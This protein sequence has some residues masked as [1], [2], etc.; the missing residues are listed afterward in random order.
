MSHVTSTT[1]F[2]NV[3]VKKK[4]TAGNTLLVIIF[5]SLYAYSL[6]IYLCSDFLFTKGFL[7][8]VYSQCFGYETQVVVRSCHLTWTCCK[9]FKLSFSAFCPNRLFFN[10]ISNCFALSLEIS[11]A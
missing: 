4:K 3:L 6:F 10:R 8:H 7:H 9:L 5:V 1:V 2:S 11:E